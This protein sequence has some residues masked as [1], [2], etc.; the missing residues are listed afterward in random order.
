M[1]VKNE[2]EKK[3]DEMAEK[4][5]KKFKKPYPLMITDCRSLSEHIEL[6]RKCIDDGELMPERKYREGDY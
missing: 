1:A 5:F 6:M 3:F 2:I 4:Y